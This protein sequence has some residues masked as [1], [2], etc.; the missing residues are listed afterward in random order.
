MVEAVET[1]STE[2]VE[3]KAGAQ[4]E[5]IDTTESEESKAT[6]ADKIVEKLQKRIGKEQSEK[7]DFEGKYE[8]AMKQIDALQKGDDPNKETEPDE[9]QKKISALEAQIK[10]QDMCDQARTVITDAGFS[11]PNSLLRALMPHRK[12]EK[13]VQF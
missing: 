3:T 8:A 9:N 11:V 5:V 4:A 13:S 12:I 2:E 10:R 7:N 1:E 6:D